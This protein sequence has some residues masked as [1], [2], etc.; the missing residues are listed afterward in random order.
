MLA[1]QLMVLEH[2]SDEPWN[3]LHPCVRQLSAVQ[4]ALNPPAD[5]KLGF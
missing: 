3:D 2:W 5:P 4:G 1:Q